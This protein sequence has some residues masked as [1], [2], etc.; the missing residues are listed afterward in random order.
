MKEAAE[1]VLS[2]QEKEWDKSTLKNLFTK[3]LEDEG[4]EIL[5]KIKVIVR[6]IDCKKVHCT[7]PDRS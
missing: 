4:D 5:E 7:K 1:M 2:S 3:Y 6:R